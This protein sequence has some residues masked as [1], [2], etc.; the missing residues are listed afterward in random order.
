MRQSPR[1]HGYAVFA[2][3]LAAA[4]LPIY[5]HAPKFYV[6]EYGIGLTA[7]AGILFALRLFDVV[8][9]P[10][11]GWLAQITRAWRGLAVGIGVLVLALSMVGLFAVVP[12]IAPLWWFALTLTGLFSS[13]SFL[14]ICFY[15]EG[16]QTAAH[17]GDKGYLRLASWRETGALLG[18]C[19]ASVAPTA[20]IVIGAPFAAFAVGFV[21]VCLLA[22]ALMRGEWGHGGELGGMG[23]RVVLADPIARRLL[24][25]ALLNSIPVAVSSTLFLFYVE[26]VLGAPGWEGPLLLLFFLAA[27]VSAPVWS[28]VASRIGTRQ[29]LLFAMALAILAF[30]MVLF[31]GPGDTLAFA[32][33]CLASGAA[34][35]ADLTLLPAAFARRMETV[36]PDAGAAFGLWAFVSK[37]SLAFAAVALLPALEGAGFVPGGENDQDALRLLTLLYAVVPCALKLLAIAL[38]AATPLADD[39]GGP[40]RSQVE[41]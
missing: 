14:T 25:I 20:L 7:L 10:V 39:A 4:G 30:G 37:L 19:V 16:V 33:I 3:M 35:G 28:R 41:R 11:L 8:Q 9:D 38:L 36:A 34:L 5:I 21:G 40:L 6:D 22:L 29:A 24:L 2:A 15:A 31:L 12:P 18:V 13:F 32:L 1:L 23:F 27:A 17:L 26:S